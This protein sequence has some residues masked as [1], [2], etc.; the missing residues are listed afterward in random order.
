MNEAEKASNA[1]ETV[2]ASGQPT[3][4]AGLVALSTSAAQGEIGQIVD[5]V[6]SRSRIDINNK[7]IPLLRNAYIAGVADGYRQRVVEEDKA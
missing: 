5:D 3:V 6:L 4:Y 1:A 2:K 7:L